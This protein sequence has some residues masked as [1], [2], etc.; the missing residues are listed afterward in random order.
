M[1]SFLRKGSF[2]LVTSTIVFLF[3]FVVIMNAILVYLCILI[4]YFN[5]KMEHQK[6]RSLGISV[7]SVY[8]VVQSNIIL[9]SFS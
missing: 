2:T 6:I 5:D 7:L 1:D 9:S 8:I 4:I 3:A